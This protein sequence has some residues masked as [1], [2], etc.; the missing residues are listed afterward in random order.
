M[1]SSMWVVPVLLSVSILICLASK[2]AVGADLPRTF[3]VNGNGIEGTGSYS[4]VNGQ[5]KINLELVLAPAADKADDGRGAVITSLPT[6]NGPN[7]SLPPNSG[8]N[9]LPAAGSGPGTSLLPTE[10]GPAEELPPLTVEDNQFIDDMVAAHNEFRSVHFSPPIQK[11]LTMSQSAKKFARRLAAKK[12]LFHSSS[13][14]RPGEGENLAMGCTTG[15]GEAITAAEAVMK[16]YEEAC[17]HDFSKNIFQN[18]SGHFTQLVWKATETIGVGRAFGEKWGM[19]CTFIVARYS[20]KGNVDTEIQFRDNVERGTFD[21]VV[22]NCSAINPAVQGHIQ[23]NSGMSNG[24]R[25]Y[26]EHKVEYRPTYHS[27]NMNRYR[28]MYYKKSNNLNSNVLRYQESES[29]D[30]AEKVPL[31]FQSRP[32]VSRFRGYPLRNRAYY[33]PQ[34]ISNNENEY[35]RPRFQIPHSAVKMKRDDKVFW[36]LS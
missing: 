17:L 31:G 13:N 7:T 8:P 35:T 32:L 4:F 33:L 5:A 18:A 14:D 30:Y 24:P 26:P 15:N 28:E 25:N 3:I 16:W 21:P 20:P 29:P 6:N 1:Q 27:N 9:T 12:E 34:F 10:N 23:P 19:N 22:F 11:N 2:K 36:F